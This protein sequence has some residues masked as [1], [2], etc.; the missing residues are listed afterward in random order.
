MGEKDQD[1]PMEWDEIQPTNYTIWES[2]ADY[3]LMI[4]RS[5][6]RIQNN[7]QIKLID[8][9]AKWIKKV[10]S[11]DLY[12]LNFDN[13]NT[14]IKI[15]E[16]ESKLFESLSNYES[17]LI[18]KSLPNELYLI[19]NDSVLKKNRLRWHENLKKDIYVEEALNVL[20]DLKLSSLGEE[21]SILN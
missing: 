20:T 16:K 21:L 2:L 7:P 18:F 6:K 13:Y 14:E 4:E 12:S 19:K 15:N 3:N 8:E 1:N 9:N 17:N 11:K 5:Q 10:Q